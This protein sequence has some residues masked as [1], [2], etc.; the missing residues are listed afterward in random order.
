VASCHEGHAMKMKMVRSVSI[1]TIPPKQMRYRTG[2]DWFFTE[3]GVLKIQVADTGNWIYNILVAIHELIEVCL[4]V[5][6]GIGQ[7]TVD[8]FDMTHEDDEDPGSHPK[9]PYHDQHMLAM[10]VEMMLS[11]AFGI[12]WRPYE[13]AIEKAFSKTPRRK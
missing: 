11:V 7:K 8:R 12:K 13:D 3:P 2:G 5:H 6:K 10:S 9:A 1:E 4:C